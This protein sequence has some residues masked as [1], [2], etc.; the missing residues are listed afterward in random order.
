MLFG[1][2][3]RSLECLS[4]CNEYFIFNKAC[5]SPH[6]YCPCPFQT[7][8]LNTGCPGDG[9]LAMSLTPGQSMWKTQV[10]DE[11]VCFGSQSEDTVY[12]CS[13]NVR[14]PRSHCVVQKQRVEGILFSLRPSPRVTAFTSTVDLLT[15]VNLVYLL[16][17][18]LTGLDPIRLIKLTVT[19]GNN[20]WI[21]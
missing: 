15:S 21:L 14:R 5:Y 3:L 12:Q 8:M 2:E 7:Q 6:H 17:G 18:T 16:V 20:H 19:D 11:S 1:K 10:R 4:T 13:R 9:V